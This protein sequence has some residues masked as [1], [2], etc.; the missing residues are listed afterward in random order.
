MVIMIKKAFCFAVLLFILVP[1]VSDA[2]TTIYPTLINNRAGTLIDS[3]TGVKF[4]LDK[5]HT[6]IT[7]VDKNGKQLWKTDPARD[8]KLEKYR[9]DKPTIA[10]FDFGMDKTGKIQV[11]HIAY[12]NSQFGYIDKKTGHFYFEGQD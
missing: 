3:K 7:A 11:I 9:V 5:S 8:N 10:Y 2:Q 4:I 1:I 6:Y 12:D